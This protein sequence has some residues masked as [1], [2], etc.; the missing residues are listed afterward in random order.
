VINLHSSSSF[1]RSLVEFSGAG[2]TIRYYEYVIAKGEIIMCTSG[3]TVFAE[4]G[5]K[6][7]TPSKL[8]REV[9]RDIMMYT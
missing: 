5:S 8:N 3:E 9:T 6:M 2:V 4:E 1:S 7:L